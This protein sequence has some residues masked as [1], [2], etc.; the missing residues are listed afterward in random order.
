MTGAIV[1]DGANAVIELERV[2]EKEEII[3]LKRPVPEGR[4]IRLPAEDVRRGECVVPKGTILEPE[5]I[6]LLA[7]IGFADVGVSR[8]PS[9]GVITT[10]SELVDPRAVPGP[11]QIRNSSAFM[12]PAYV[13]EAGGQV[14]S[15]WSVGDDEALLADIINQ[16]LGTDVV[17]TTGGISVGKYDLVRRVLE[18][19]GV[20]I[21][22][23]GVNIK[24]GKPLAFG[25]A[26]NGTPVFCLPG[27]PVSSVVTFWRFVRPAFD[28]MMGRRWKLKPYCRAE[29]E[30][31]IVKKDT[32]E[33]YLRGVFTLG[34]AIPSVRLTGIQ[35][36]GAL[37]SMSKANCLIVLPPEARTFAAGEIVEIQLL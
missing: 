16:S 22:I 1:P 13:D 9:V 23:A 26:R 31:E 24:P 17:I 28:Q 4:N 5:H 20:R 29:L 36:S 27:N 25:V 7:S 19:L 30:E 8:K 12:L 21:K 37:S 14:E 32:K 35:S 33:H 10:G 15:L 11:G 18:S 34:T 2:D 3:A 6:G